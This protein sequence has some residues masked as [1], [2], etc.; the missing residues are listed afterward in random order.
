MLNRKAYQHNTKYDKAT[1]AAKAE[2]YRKCQLDTACS[3]RPAAK[4]DEP[5]RVLCRFA[6]G[7]CPVGE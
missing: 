3:A 6:R 2:V 5:P 1:L 4:N 7:A